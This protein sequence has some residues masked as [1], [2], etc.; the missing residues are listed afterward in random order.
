MY[1]R[2]PQPFEFYDG[3]RLYNLTEEKSKKADTDGP[4]QR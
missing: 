1:K 4:S 2:V 3:H